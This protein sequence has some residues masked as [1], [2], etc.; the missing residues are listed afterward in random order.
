MLGV[1][2]SEIGATLIAL[3]VPGIKPIFDK[4][5]LNKNPRT[6][7]GNSNYLKGSSRHSKG[8]A[9]STLRLRSQHSKL[10]SRENTATYQH[11]VSASSRQDDQGQGEEGILVRVD[12]DVKEEDQF[13]RDGRMR[14]GKHGHVQ[15]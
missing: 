1:E 14:G 5:V 12:F 6:E 4:Y 2:T 3:S 11:E 8:T 9:L 7:S 10:A 15:T 13:G